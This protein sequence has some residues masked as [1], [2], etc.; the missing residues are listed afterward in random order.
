M[1]DKSK[2]LRIDSQ[3]R[4]SYRHFLSQT[5]DRETIEDWL[6]TAS[7]APSGANKQPWHFVVV[8]DDIIKPIF[9]RRQKQ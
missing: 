8:T 7:S 2:Q 5:I 6:M 4:R 1:N 3:K 9:A